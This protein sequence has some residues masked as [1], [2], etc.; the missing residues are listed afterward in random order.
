MRKS[1]Y[2]ETNFRIFVTLWR[3]KGKKLISKLT[4]K[5]TKNLD[6]VVFSKII[7][8]IAYWFKLNGKRRNKL[9][10]IIVYLVKINMY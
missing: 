10:S 1:A 7:L 9:L 6:F 2:K 4:S 8:L 3:E 5:V